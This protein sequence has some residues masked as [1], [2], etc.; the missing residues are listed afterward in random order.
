MRMYRFL[1]RASAGPEFER[2]PGLVADFG[3]AT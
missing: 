3:A 2:D 1:T